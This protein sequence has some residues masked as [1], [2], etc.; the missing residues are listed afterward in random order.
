LSN[1]ERL[2][3]HLNLQRALKL[4]EPSGRLD[5]KTIPN[6]LIKFHNLIFFGG[7]M[8]DILK[9]KPIRKFLKERET[10]IP[11][12]KIVD[13]LGESLL[14]QEIGLP[15]G[16]TPEAAIETVA[17]SAWARG[18]AEGVCGPGYAGFTP[19]TP[20]FDRC[21][22]NVSHRVAARVLG[23]SWTPPAAPPAPTPPRRRR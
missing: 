18:L 11:R 17:R 12:P 1:R 14:G 5:S 15:P 4:R 16:V 19:G 10:L 22:Y 6:K 21:V 8:A 23:L 20:E 13:I 3:L 7:R 2:K 9:D